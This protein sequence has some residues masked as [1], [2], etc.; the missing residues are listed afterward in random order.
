MEQ[1][2]FDSPWN[3]ATIEG[4]LNEVVTARGS[5]ASLSAKIATKQDTLTLDTEPT[6]NSTNFVNSGAIY[7]ALQSAGAGVYVY[8]HKIYEGTPPEEV[9]YDTS[10]FTKL[11]STSIPY[12]SYGA[13]VAERLAVSDETAISTLQAG[14]W[15]AS[16]MC[17][18]E[19]ENQV[20]AY[21]GYEWSAA[22]HL[23]KC[24]VWLNRY[25]EQNITLTCKVQWKDS[26]NNWHDVDTIDITPT[27]A[28]PS[29]VE[30][31]TLD[32]SDDAYGIRWIHTTPNKSSNNNITFAGM[33]VYGRME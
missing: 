26:S 13:R 28:Y 6:E 22:K 29:K 1:I 24:K 20:G 4:V 33:T 31:I 19:S 5:E 23:T 2:K 12:G 16:G 25:S 10:G 30:T 21:A 11:Y 27:Y 14:G 18:Y 9:Q 3:V 32:P 17:Y 7:A 8:Q 15:S